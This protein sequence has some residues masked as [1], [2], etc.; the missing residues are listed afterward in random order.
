ML[1]GISVLFGILVLFGNS[2]DPKIGS[3][4]LSG[5]IASETNSPVPE[6]KPQRLFVWYQTNS[7]S[8]YIGYLSGNIFYGVSRYEYK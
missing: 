8:H 2:M 5:Q 3:D 4:Y 1:F 7:L 6:D